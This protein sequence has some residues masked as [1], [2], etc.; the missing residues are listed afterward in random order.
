MFVGQILVVVVGYVCL[1]LVCFVFGVALLVGG[2]S[3]PF[4][5]D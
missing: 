4:H 3:S 5:I 1:V 2:W